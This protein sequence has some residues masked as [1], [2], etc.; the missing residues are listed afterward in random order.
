MD[1]PE[2]ETPSNDTEALAITVTQI[3]FVVL[4]ILTIVI[5]LALFICKRRKRVLKERKSQL[6]FIEGDDD[7]ETEI[8]DQNMS[9]Y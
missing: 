3:I 5:L 4:L 2:P 7:L 8:N 6:S 1:I 9:E